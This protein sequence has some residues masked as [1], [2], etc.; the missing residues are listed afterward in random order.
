MK[1]KNI[2]ITLAAIAALCLAFSSCG[3]GSSKNASGKK[4]GKN[5]ILGNMP[6]IVYQ[7]ALKDSVLKAEFKAKYD[8]IEMKSE[9]DLKKAASIVKEEKEEQEKVK[10]EFTETIAKEKSNL[11]GKSI[12][13]EMEEE[14]GYEITKF[15]ITDI[16]SDGRVRS[17]IEVRITDINSAKILRGG[18][19]LLMAS[20]DI[21]K[22]GNQ[23]GNSGASY[24]VSI[25]RDENGATGNTYSYIVLHFT[26]AAQYA[27]F[28]KIK[29]VKP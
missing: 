10:S 8:K 16:E 5:E 22:N 14:L 23:I 28:A 6:D 27:D 11:I 25:T 20:Q 1:T 9:S 12:P 13:F 29:F 4:I 19:Q 15:V 3:G 7:K 18:G 24:Y 21:D 26:N 2:I 17:E